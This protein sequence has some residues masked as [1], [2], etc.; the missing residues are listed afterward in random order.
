M[1]PR[2]LLDTEQRYGLRVMIG[3]PWEQHIA[4]LDDTKIVQSIEA[5]I[6]A[7]V[8]AC[9]GRPAILCYVLGNEILSA[10]MCWHRAK[11]VERFLHNQ[12]DES[13][14]A[15]ACA[16]TVA[17]SLC[18]GIVAPLFYLALGGV[19]LAFAYK[20]VNTLDSM[21]GHREAPYTYFGRFAARVDDAANFVPARLPVL[22]IVASAKILKADAKAS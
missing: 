13:E 17:E 5:Q 19:P 15:R 14:I 1:P 21:I 11:R 8:H 10:V 22:F 2:W 3:L 18:D 20:A 9:A 16:E 6:R 4:F 7:V 12:L